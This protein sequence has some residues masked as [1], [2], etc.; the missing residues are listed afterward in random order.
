VWHAAGIAR[1][2]LVADAGAAL[3]VLLV[4]TVLAVYKPRGMTRY[5]RRKQQEERRR[6]QYEQR[7]ARVP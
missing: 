1:L 7:T 5:G 4:A 3:L 2:P 6:K